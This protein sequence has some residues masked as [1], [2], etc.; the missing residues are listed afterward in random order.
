M[1]PKGIRIGTKLYLG[2]TTVVIIFGAICLFQILRINMLAEL[3]DEGAGRASDA[4]VVKDIS[5]RVAGV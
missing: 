1:Q 5:E 2:F 3:Q 4:L